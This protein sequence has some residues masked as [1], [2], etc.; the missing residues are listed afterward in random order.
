MLFD[1]NVER[2]RQDGKR[3]DEDDLAYLNLSGRREAEEVRRFI[4]SCLDRY[5]REHR[6]ELIQRMRESDIQ[7][8]SASFELFLHSG[9]LQLGWTVHIHPEVPGGNG[10]R[11]DFRVCTQTGDAFYVEATLARSRSDA[12]LAAERRKNEV[13]RAID[14]MPSP[15]FL[16]DVD[17]DGSPRTTVPRRNLRH[18]LRHWLAG[19]DVNEVKAQFANGR[20]RDELRYEHDGW[21]IVFKPIPRRRTGDG[22]GGRS[23]GVRGLGIRTVSIV[24]AVKG[25]AKSK[26]SRYG[27]LDLPLVV[28]IN[29]QEDF[30]DTTQERDALFGE[31]QFWLPRNGGPMRPARLPNGVWYGPRGPQCTRLSGAWLFRRFDCWHFVVRGSNLLYVNPD[32]ALPLAESAL[33][34]P[35]ARV[36]GNRLVERPGLKFGEI[37]NLS[38][39]WPAPS[40]A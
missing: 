29:I 32:A 14:D 24:E 4:E 2:T 6:D 22:T 23:I 17:I 19:L 25:A 8:A 39:D 30:V 15:H 18:K 1:Q 3:E 21:T 26:A 38:D 9:F 33:R 10:R 12:E 37:F 31:L 16:L 34:F 40:P 13:L 28:A 11:P 7:F 20:V 36:E 27:V 35:F 5:P